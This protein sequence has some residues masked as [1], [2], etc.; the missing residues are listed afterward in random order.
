MTQLGLVQD[1]KELAFRDEVKHLVDWCKVNDLIL[2][3]DKTKEVIVDFRKS[4]PSHT[5]LLI[6]DTAVKV[7][8]S[9]EFLGV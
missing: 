1:N 5:P 6:D 3:V 2:N 4:R 8:S 7:V 9:T